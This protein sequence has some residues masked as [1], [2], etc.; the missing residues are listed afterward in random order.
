MEMPRVSEVCCA[1]YLAKDQVMIDEIIS[2]KDMH[3]AN[4]QQFGLPSRL[5]AKVLVFRILYGGTEYGFVNDP[6]FTEVSTSTKYWKKAIDAFY[7][8][9]KDIHKWHTKLVQEAIQTGKVVMPTGRQYSFDPFKT[10]RGELKW[11]RAR[12]LNYPVQGFGAD[13]MNITRV[14]FWRKLLNE[15]VDCKLIATVHDSIVV[16]APDN[17]V[18]RVVR[19]MNDSFLETPAAFEQLFGVEYNLPFNTEI[20]V[21]KDYKNMVEVDLKSSTKSNLIL[22]DK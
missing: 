13:M 9:Y 7:N 10:P 17:E 21:G 8:K 19:L 22:K 12:I 1:A 11:P 20:Q 15:N 4:R 14:L 5:I 2:G 3:E 16:D 18:A 6:D